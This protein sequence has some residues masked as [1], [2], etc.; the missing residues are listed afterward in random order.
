MTNMDPAMNNDHLKT[1]DSLPEPSDDDVTDSLTAKWRSRMKT[2]T[3]LKLTNSDRRELR[4]VMNPMPVQAATSNAH[5][6]KANHP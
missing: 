5:R 1:S 3:S 2:M 4:R 6:K